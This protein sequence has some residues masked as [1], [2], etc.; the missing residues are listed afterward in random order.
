MSRKYIYHYNILI[1][2][3]FKE[4]PVVDTETPPLHETNAVQEDQYMMSRKGFEKQQFTITC[5]KCRK[6]CPLDTIC[7]CL[8]PSLEKV[9]WRKGSRKSE[10]LPTINFEDTRCVF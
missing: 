7:L 9:E 10:S 2:T 4:T 3:R 1:S 6:Q 8:P 5:D